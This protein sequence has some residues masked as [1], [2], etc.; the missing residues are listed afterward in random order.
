MVSKTA[1][2]FGGNWTIE[3]LDIFSAYLNYYITA[4]K[5]QSFNKIYIDAFAGTGSISIN[6]DDITVEG[7]VRRALNAQNKFDHYYFIEKDD[8]KID[9]LKQVVNKEYPDLKNIVTIIHGD[10]NIELNDLCKNINWKKNRALLLLDPYA[11]EVKWETL[12]TIAK[13]KAIDFWYLFPISAVQ[14]MMPNKGNILPGCR[15]KLNQI[16]GD[17]SWEEEFYREDPQ[18]SFDQSTRYQKEIN[19][20]SLKNYINK[21]LRTIFPKVA[22]NSRVLYNKMNCP[23]FLFCFA[24]ANDK[25]KAVSLAFK[26]ANYILNLNKKDS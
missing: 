20:E 3:K 17:D 21:R 26:G 9:E 18:I 14:R 11:T 12:V 1:H 24:V 10:C 7:S 22:D 23:L 6:N 5:K 4:L 15:D 19:I 8:S 2:R 25:E 16:F 13:T